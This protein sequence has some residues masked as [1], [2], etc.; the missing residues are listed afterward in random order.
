[1]TTKDNDCLQDVSMPGFSA[2]LTI[3]DQ[4]AQRTFAQ[5]AEPCCKEVMLKECAR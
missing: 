3:Y 1:M 5:I 4:L 2:D